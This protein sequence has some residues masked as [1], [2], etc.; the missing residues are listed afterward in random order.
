MRSNYKNTINVLALASEWL[1]IFL[2]IYANQNVDL[3]VFHTLSIIVIGTRIH[4]LG[5]LMHEAS[6]F[7]LFTHY[8]A[9]DWIASLFITS[10]F[11]ISLDSYRQSHMAHHQ[12][13]LT[14][15]DPTHARKNG[16]AIF[17]FPKQTTLNF[18]KQ[19][20]KITLGYGIYLSLSDLS[21]NQKSRPK[22]TSRLRSQI[23]I[24]IGLFLLIGLLASPYR[25]IALL[26]WILPTLTIVPLLNYW[27]TISEHS[28]LNTAEPTRTVVYP[29]L[30]QWLLT[31]YN[32]NY[33][34]EHH[35]FPKKPWYQLKKLSPIEQEKL[36]HGHTTYGFTNLWN[37]FVR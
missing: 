1:I 35:L 13:S 23:S 33:H 14:E 36:P 4:A 17:E 28:G 7:N 25:N 21:R 6:H 9:N 12:F 34:L 3:V 19:L 37:E 24:L 10:P 30:T 18:L 27:R 20:I 8:S 2:L 16:I 5:I 26:Y 32:V 29:R 15:K 31:P 22:S 11:F